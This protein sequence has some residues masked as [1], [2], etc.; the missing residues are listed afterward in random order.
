M[1]YLGYVLGAYA[2]FAVFLAWDFWAPRLRLTRT[3]R[4]IAARA[5]RQAAR[6]DGEPSA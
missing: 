6:A 2:V 5:R 1:S 3:R 4:E